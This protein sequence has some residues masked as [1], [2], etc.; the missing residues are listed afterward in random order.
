MRLLEVGQLA[1]LR[2]GLRDALFL[3]L[4][5]IGHVL[6][7]SCSA[8]LLDLLLRLGSDRLGFRLGELELKYLLCE[9]REG[10]FT[11]FVSGEDDDVLGT[12]AHH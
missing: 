1:L 4:Q 10:L 5:G 12:G 6:I 9:L 11:L 7:S 3:L 8:D 2:V